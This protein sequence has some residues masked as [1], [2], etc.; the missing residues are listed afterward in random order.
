M[1]LGQLLLLL[2]SLRLP[3]PPT[4]PEIQSVGRLEPGRAEER[5][6]SKGKSGAQRQ[7]LDGGSPPSMKECGHG[8]MEGDG[9]RI[10]FMPP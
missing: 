8:R 7:E 5:I 4:S 1:T 6:T 3:L 2:V 9:N 10:A